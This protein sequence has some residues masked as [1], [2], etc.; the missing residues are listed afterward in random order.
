MD[1]LSLKFI[2]AVSARINVMGSYSQWWSV[3][4]RIWI[5]IVVVASSAILTTELSHY[6]CLANFD[7][8]PSPLAPNSFVALKQVLILALWQSLFNFS[9]QLHT[10]ATFCLCHTWYSL[11]KTFTSTLSAIGSRFTPSPDYNLSHAISKRLPAATMTRPHSTVA[12][13][14]YTSRP[15]NMRHREKMIREPMPS[16]PKTHMPHSAQRNQG[17]F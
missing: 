15:I 16:I 1:I 3:V 2:W 11:H 7:L 17:I 6:Y 12:G 14:S 9:N 8:K 10:S 13:Y 4:T 5:Q